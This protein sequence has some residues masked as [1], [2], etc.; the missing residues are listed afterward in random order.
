MTAAPGRD[1]AT[2]RD[3]MRTPVIAP[4][5]DRATLE[6]SSGGSGAAPRIEHKHSPEAIRERAY[7]IYCKRCECGEDGDSHSDWDKA[8]REISIA[9]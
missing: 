3:D 7:Q 9:P 4:A 2:R 8:V 1:A 5:T 6:L